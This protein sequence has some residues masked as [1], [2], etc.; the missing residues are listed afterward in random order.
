MVPGKVLQLSLGGGGREGG[1]CGQGRSHKQPLVFSLLSLAKLLSNAPHKNH[2]KL[3][4]SAALAL[5]HI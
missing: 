5:S 1:G 4:C 3:H 2:S